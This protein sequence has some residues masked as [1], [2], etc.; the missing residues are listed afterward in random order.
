MYR[1]YTSIDSR[2]MSIYLKPTSI[3]CKYTDE[4]GR[5]Y[6]SIYRCAPPH[7]FFFFIPLTPRV[8]WNKRLLVLHTSP[9]RDRFTF[10]YSSCS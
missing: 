9:S 2:Y 4:S 8:E 5:Q 6:T 10:L 3:Y 7:F 1:N